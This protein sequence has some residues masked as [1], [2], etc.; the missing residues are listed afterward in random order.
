MSQ[1]YDYTIATAFPNALVDSD[2]LKQE[3]QASAIV[4][5]LD[6]IGTADGV[7]SIWFK[8]AL[9]GGDQTV[10]DG[11][12]AA[13]SGAPFAQPPMQFTE[14][15]ANGSPLPRTS[16]GKSV[17]V[18][19]PTEGNK[20]TI[21]SPNWCDPTTWISHAA[22]VVDETATDSGDHTTY[23]LA[24]DKVIDVYHGKMSNEDYFKDGGGHSYRVVVKVNGTTKTEQDPHTGTGGDYTIN[25]AAGSVTFLS[26]L[27]DGD[28]VTVTYH[29]ATDSE[30]V[31]KPT[32]GKRLS[33]RRAEVQFSE[34]IGLTDSITFNAY[35]LVDVF[36]PQL[37]Q[38]NVLP[39]GTMIPLG[40][41]VVYKTMLDFIND[42]N[43]AYPV[44]PAMGGNT[45]RGMSKAISIFGWDYAAMTQLVSTYGMEIRIKL[46][47]DTP[48][49][50][51]VATA[52]FYCLSEDL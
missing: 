7:C 26:A 15:L 36:A 47:H 16:D 43:G 5:A 39:S 38:N 37:V 19:W 9:S 45:W 34:D 46:E 28:T 50:G 52:T 40:D 13:H 22:R 1:K 18:T 21:V 25:Y 49:T 24:H 12:V 51:T 30:F 11:I 20:T 8:A 32:S 42:A 4:T 3:I 35:G 14:V 17:V 41:P 23:T 44:I 6:Y 10:L 2:R 33:L 48:L 31:L 27:Q 29:H